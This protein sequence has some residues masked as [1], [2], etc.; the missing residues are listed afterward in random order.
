MVRIA[1]K[2]TPKAIRKTVNL[3]E[4]DHNC[5]VNFATQH[6]IELRDA[7]SRMIGFSYSLWML[8]VSA[9]YGEIGHRLRSK[10]A[11]FSE[12]IGHPLLGGWSSAEIKSV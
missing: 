1:Y 9:Y 11:A 7:I 2:T 5:L 3:S 10:P 4:Y 12:Q 8:E 6:N